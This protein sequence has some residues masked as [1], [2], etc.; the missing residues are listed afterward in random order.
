MGPAAIWRQGFTFNGAY[1][2]GGTV[3]QDFGS[4]I[5]IVLANSFQILVS[6]LYL[7]YN[8]ILTRQLVADEWTR[9]LRPN[10]KKALR[11]SSPKAVQRSSYSLS[12]PLKYSIPLMVA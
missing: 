10:G 12:L 4:G 8:N 5:N 6:F 9:F 11:V 2:V 1:L 7:F 3:S